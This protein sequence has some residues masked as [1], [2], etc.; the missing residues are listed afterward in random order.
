MAES[1]GRPAI[2]KERPCAFLATFASEAVVDY[3]GIYTPKGKPFRFGFSQFFLPIDWTV[4]F[5]QWNESN[6]PRTK[7]EAFKQL[8]EG[9]P[10]KTEKVD[11]INYA[12]D[13]SGVPGNNFA[14]VA[15]GNFEVAEGDYVLNVTTDDG[16]R[17][18]VDGNL[19]IKDAWKYQGPT[20]YTAPLKL[21]GGKHRI[22]V[23]HFEIDGYS[24]LKVELVR[25]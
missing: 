15:E 21:S 1:H 11:R 23:E 25:R 14:T 13:I 10:V 18:W 9:T 4:K 8:I 3:R 5:F 19:V 22:R 20:L 17:V 6:D 16:A 2:S 7:P 12:G 24:A